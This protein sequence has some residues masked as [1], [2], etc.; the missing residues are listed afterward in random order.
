MVIPKP[1]VI[2]K[3]YNGNFVTQ[4]WTM[5]TNAKKT[6]VTTIFYETDLLKIQNNYECRG[7]R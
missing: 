2:N 7:H 6:A 1:L 3:I 5:E 4:N